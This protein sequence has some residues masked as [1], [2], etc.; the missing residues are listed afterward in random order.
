MC[1]GRQ[2][3]ILQAV[4]PLDTSHIKPI[5]ANL[6]SHC[7]FETRVTEEGMHTSN[8]KVPET[9]VRLLL[10]PQHPGGTSHGQHQVH[11]LVI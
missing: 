6:P 11:I 8:R 7:Y 5:Q 2:L 9:T 4:S 10:L 1:V 3:G